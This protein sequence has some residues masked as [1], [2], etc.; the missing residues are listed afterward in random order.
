ML[1]RDGAIL[2]RVMAMAM[3]TEMGMERYFG[4]L[5]LQCFILK[6]FLQPDVRASWS[7]EDFVLLSDDESIWMQWLFCKYDTHSIS[8]AISDVMFVIHQ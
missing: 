8:S 5:F 1:F 7:D 4:L 3:V 6:L 2:G